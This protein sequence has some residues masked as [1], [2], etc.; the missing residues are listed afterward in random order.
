MEVT[1]QGNTLYIY[2]PENLVKVTAEI[3]DDDRSYSYLVLNFL[4]FLKFD[5][6]ARFFFIQG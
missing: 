2:Q 1:R 6:C 3:V 4:D 5:F